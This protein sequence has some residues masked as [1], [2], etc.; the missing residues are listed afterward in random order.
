[1]R[2][3]KLTYRGVLTL[4]ILVSLLTMGARPLLFHTS[5]AKLPNRSLSLQDPKQG[6]TTT[7]KFSFDIATAN[8]IGSIRFQFCSDSPL[9]EYPCTAPVGF[10]GSAATIGSQNGE[11]GF[12]VGSNTTANEIF[13]TRAPSVTSPGTTTYELGGIKNPSAQGTYFVRVQTYASTDGSGTSIDAGGLAFV[14]NDAVD[15]STYVP[16]YLLFCSGLTITDYD[17]ATAS[18]DYINFGELSSAATKYA[19]SQM[20]VATNVGTGY[21][22]S[23]DGTTM[24][25]G[26]EV[27]PGLAASDVSRPGTSQFGLNLAGNTS[28]GI[29]ENV[30]GPGTGVPTANY[31]IPDRFRFI[32]GEQLAGST[33]VSDYRKYTV[34][35][36]INIEKDQPPGLYASTMTY[37]CLANF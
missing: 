27:I 10:D 32:P 26:N 37:V 12:N 29:G 3:Q 11:T 24:T 22:L 36:I 25:A 23:L 8:S 1:M 16:P 15:I 31:A 7:Y 6:A 17:C 33:S 21:V 4:G 30:N 34:S 9:I 5:A 19:K 14:T 20:V 2:F 28:P 35:Y 18:G 13:L